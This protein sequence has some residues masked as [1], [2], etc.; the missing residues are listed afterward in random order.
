M[1]H[2]TSR[3]K[4]TI[5]ISNA[6][7]TT[8]AESYEH[9][10]AIQGPTDVLFV[11]SGIDLGSFGIYDFT[12]NYG[13]GSSIKNIEPLFINR[14][15]TEL[16]LS[17]VEH[18]FY[19]TTS[20]S[21][22]VNAQIV[23]RYLSDAGAIPSIVTHNIKLKQSAGNTIEKN[24]EILNTQLFTI[25]AEAVPLI[26]LESDEN[27]IYP[28]AFIEVEDVERIDDN[29]YINTDPETIDLD[30]EYLYRSDVTLTQD[31]DNFQLSALSGSGF[32]LQGKSGK[33]Y[34]AVFGISG[35]DLRYTY[36]Q[37]TTSI[38]LST[39][40][41]SYPGIS[42]LQGT[43]ITLF[44]SNGLIGTEFSLIS[45]AGNDIYFY[46][47]NQLPPEATLYTYTTSVS[48]TTAVGGYAPYTATDNIYSYTTNSFGPSGNIGL[49][50][51]NRMKTDPNG[52][53]IRA[54]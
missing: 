5:D 24:I 30:A 12:A 49:S 20:A 6:V 43:I 17:A 18:T 28:C 48:S 1:A 37:N 9:I 32:T 26:N 52:L 16:S 13:D 11:L 22:E 47:S 40:I 21:S 41:S 45:S 3:H 33:L 14:L 50:A 38:V 42:G 8:S 23:A 7:P 51:V 25:S 29:I 15:P 53:L 35:E 31:L 2:L 54:L 36:T 19:Q 10:Y 39:D 44:D 34:T 46:Q 4:L 27:I